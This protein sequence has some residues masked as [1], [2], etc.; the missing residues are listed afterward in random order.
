M[1]PGWIGSYIVL[2]A[3]ALIGWLLWWID[4]RQDR[5]PYC[6]GKVAVLSTDDV[7][8]ESRR[9]GGDALGS[10]TLML[11]SDL[12]RCRACLRILQR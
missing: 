2:G 1:T 4:S 9:Q 7:I 5:C 10:L 3:T 6:R 8:M 11:F 12:G